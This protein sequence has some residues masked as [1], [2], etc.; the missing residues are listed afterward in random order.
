M[1]AKRWKLGSVLLM[2]LVTLVL[3]AGLARAQGPGPESEMAVTENAVSAVSPGIPIQGRLT[4]A[5][6]APLNG[7]HTLHFRLYG[8]SSGSDLVCEDTDT[9]TVEDGLFFSEIVGDCNTYAMNG[10]ALYLSVQV[11]SDPEMTP[12]QAIRAVPYAYSLRPGA[13]ISDTLNNNSIVDIENWG[14]TGRGIRVYAM[15]ETGTNYGI[16][17][18]SRSPD[19]YGGYF[20]NTSDGVALGVSGSGVIQSSADSYVFV[21]GTASVLFASS[22]GATLKYWGAGDVAL[23]ATADTGGKEIVFPVTLPAVLY[24]QPVRLEDVSFTFRVTGDLTA[25]QR[26]RVYR[27]ATDGSHRTILDDTNGGGGWTSLTWQQVTLPISGDNVFAADDG[28]LTVRITCGVYAG[29]EVDFVG[30]RVRLG[31]N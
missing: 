7:S 31:H 27:M 23:E 24:G 5:A 10:R 20:Y 15:S 1:N 8:S 19:G 17:G 14:A 16:V 28:S 18:A 6:G 4:D 21:P 30:V 25:V 2:A 22:S 9:V 13:T 11:G 26:V 12:R 3:A 29:N